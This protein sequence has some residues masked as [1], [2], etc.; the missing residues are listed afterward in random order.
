MIT[1]HFLIR[2]LRGK[3][4]IAHANLSECEELEEIHIVLGNYDILAKGLFA[5]KEELY[6]FIQNKMQIIEGIKESNTLLVME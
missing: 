6:A 1:V 4:K 5:D 3:L 2:T